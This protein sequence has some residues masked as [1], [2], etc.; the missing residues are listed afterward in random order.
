M[1]C[2]SD[3]CYAMDYCTNQSIS[4]ESSKVTPSSKDLF[5]N[6]QKLKEEFG[7]ELIEMMIDIISE[8]LVKENNY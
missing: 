5:S 1:Y 8:E 2:L 7:E 3:Y 6:L 4:E